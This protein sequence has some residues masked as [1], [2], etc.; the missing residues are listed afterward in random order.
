[1]EN[2]IR[3][4]LL[5]FCLVLLLNGCDKSIPPDNVDFGNIQTIKALEG[6]YQNLGEGEQGYEP[7]YLSSV[8]WPKLARIDHSS[9]TT[10]EVRFLNPNGLLVRAIS[11]T[12]VYKEEMFVEGKDF[13]THSGR[14]RL[15]QSISLSKDGFL[16][17]MY[18][19]KQLGLDRKGQGKLKTQGGFAGLVMGFI[20]YATGGSSEVRFIR[21]EK[22]TNP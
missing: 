15:K 4:L 22:M 17:P 1:M 3:K 9:I 10:I 12:G 21:M 19:Q 11:R 5:L 18:E 6:V 16:G 14:I 8:I 20:P 7:I 13:E 2:P